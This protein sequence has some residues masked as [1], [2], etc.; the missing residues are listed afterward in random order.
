M[1]LIVLGA[2]LAAGVMVGRCRRFAAS[3]KGLSDAAT[4]NPRFS[5][6][7]NKNGHHRPISA[8]HNHPEV[9]TFLG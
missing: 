7:R 5:N 6:K 1:D 8:T 3:A 2:E 9:V 4:M